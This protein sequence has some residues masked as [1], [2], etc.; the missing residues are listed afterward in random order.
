MI[1]DSESDE[2]RQLV[3][4]A[5]VFYGTVSESIFSLFKMM[6]GD[7]E[8]LEPM[9]MTA[10]GKI[11]FVIFMVVA[12]WAIL[13]ILTSVV[14]DNMIS[15]ST[16]DKEK[17]EE[18]ETYKKDVE[19]KELIQEL[20]KRIDHNHNGIISEDEWTQMLSDRDTRYE[21]MEASGLEEQFLQDLFMSLCHDEEDENGEKTKCLSYAHFVEHMKDESKVANQRSMMAMMAHFK[22]LDSKIDSLVNHFEV[23]TLRSRK[24]SIASSR[25]ANGNKSPTFNPSSVQ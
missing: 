15:A 6:N 8:P 11:L 14:S 7:T 19:R 25:V 16:R 13:A 3:T 5:D 20:F 22:A 2:F 17:E 4:D 10:V 21:L 24:T 23:Q 12:N 18:E 9:R 1:F